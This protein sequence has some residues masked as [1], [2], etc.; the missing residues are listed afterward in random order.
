MIFWKRS[1][2]YCRN[3]F[4]SSPLSPDEDFL[5]S[6]YIFNRRRRQERKEEPRPT[7][8]NIYPL[9]SSITHSPPLTLFCILLRR[10]LKVIYFSPSSTLSLHLPHLMHSREGT[11]MTHFPRDCFHLTSACASLASRLKFCLSNRF[12]PSL[13]PTTPSQ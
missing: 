2:V 1:L 3:G 4:R 12:Y 8:V 6:C 11:R 7:G 5:G 9:F 13:T 10:N